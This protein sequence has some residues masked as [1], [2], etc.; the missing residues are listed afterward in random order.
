MQGLTMEVLTERGIERRP[1]ARVEH[2]G[3]REIQIPELRAGETMVIAGDGRV[4]ITASR[5][6]R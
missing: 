6:R 1:V 3:P 4:R 2:Q 5:G